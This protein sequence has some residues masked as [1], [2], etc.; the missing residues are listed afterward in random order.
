[1]HA[2]FAETIAEGVAAGELEPCDAGRAADFAI[3]LVD[4]YGVRALVGDPQ[5]DVDAA[6]CEIWAALAEH[7]G[8]A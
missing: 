6:R 3:A 7:L 2:W 8:V 5:L 1:M 4:G